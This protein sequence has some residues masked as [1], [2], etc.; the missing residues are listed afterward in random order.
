MSRKAL[1]RAIAAAVSLAAILAIAGTAAAQ[2]VAA[3]GY[4][5]QPLVSDQMG[6]APTTDAKL[7]TPGESS[8]DRRRR[9]G[10][11]TTSAIRPPSTT[12]PGSRS[13]RPRHS[14]SG[15]GSPTGTVFNG[16][17]SFLLRARPACRPP[18]SSSRPRPARSSA[19]TAAPPRSWELT[20]LRSTR[21][22]P[23]S[24]LRNRLFAADFHNRR[25]DMFDG[26]FHLIL[27]LGGAGL[28]RP[29]TAAPLLALRDPELGR[30][31]LRRI[32]ADRRRRRRRIPGPG[33]GIVDEYD[34]NGKLLARVAS[35]GELNA[36]WGITMRRE[37]LRTAVGTLVVG[38]F[39]DGHLNGYAKDA[40]G[41]WMH[42]D[43]LRGTNGD[44]IEIVGLWGIGFGRRQ[45][46][47]HDLALLRPGSTTRHTASSA[48]SPRR[49]ETAH[50]IENGR[51]RLYGAVT[52]GSR[53]TRAG[54]R[55]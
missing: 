21:R 4:T 24:R 25:V 34:T 42:V 2:R 43:Q 50:G 31:H 19:G 36:P 37:R 55:S 9:G 20:G 26:S 5:V 17:S 48:R 28:L 32:R 44:P 23:G 6:N 41:H 16:G 39:G 3:T 12:G 40:S 14:S 52:S 22:T 13:R 54:P 46:R 11:R 51:R 33:L 1:A 53:S 29:N 18:G 35:H 47:A 7:A 15:P 45:R 27:T 49:A 8:P 10:S 30:P 38:N